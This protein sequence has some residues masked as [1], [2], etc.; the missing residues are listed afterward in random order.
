MNEPAKARELLKKVAGKKSDYDHLVEIASLQTETSE[1]FADN[2]GDKRPQMKALEGKY[3]AFV[4]K[5]PNFI[6]GYSML[7][8]IQSALD[9]HHE[10]IQTVIA[11]LNN[12][13][14][15]KRRSSNLWSMYRNLTISFAE[16]GD[17]R[18]ALGAAD[19]A[20]ELKKGISSDRYFMYALAKADAATGNFKG[21]QDALNVVA[22]RVPEVKNDPKFQSTVRFLADKIQESKQQKK[23]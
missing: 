3:A 7:G 10:A 8:G 12:T 5:Y 9:E 19:V 18:K 20:Y 6:P 13:P 1:L 4:R 22:A 17:Y 15:D 16:T 11:A 2:R 14:K 23:Q 21:A